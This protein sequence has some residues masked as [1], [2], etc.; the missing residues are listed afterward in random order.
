[1]A[2]PDN[3][4]V[5]ADID[6]V[7]EPDNDPLATRKKGT[8]HKTVCEMERRQSALVSI[9]P[10]A[11]ALRPSPQS[12]GMT[13]LLT[14]PVAA[15]LALLAILFLSA[16]AALAQRT[17]MVVLLNGDRLTCDV[18]ELERNRL[19]VSTD[20]MGSVRIDWD[21]VLRVSSPEP[22][23]IELGDGRRLRGSLVDSGVDRMLMVDA[24]GESITLDMGEVVRIDE[25]M[26]GAITDRWDGQVSVGLNYTQANNT[27][28]FS[29]AFDA[30]R[31]DENF[32]LTVNA[33]TF[34]RSQ[35]EAS[36][37]RRFN[38]GLE[39]RRLLEER[40][41]WAALGL[42]ERNDELGVDLRSLAGLGYGRFLTQTNRSLW[43]ATAGIAVT[44]EQRAGDSS[45]ND[46]EGYL[47]TRYEFFLYDT[48]ETSLN[49]AVTLFPGITDSGRLRA[50]LTFYIKRELISDLFLEL[51]VYGSFDNRQPDE[52][53]RSDY[54]LVTSVGYSF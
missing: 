20:S 36:D 16:E 11:E 18:R 13:R 33:S 45:Q 37:T 25:V 22:F 48:P 8:I 34:V 14:S 24:A 47:D 40:W 54:G 5:I 31:R 3:P 17:G 51:R 19:R 4:V 44:D 53:E 10:T 29:G 15:M 26:E 42:L 12:D 49:T 7:A 9:L 23:I 32:Q 27:T 41:Y 50:N 43:S 21:D 28:A 35:D 6:L 52:A 1:M 2:L 46:V 38:V 39:Y 30:R